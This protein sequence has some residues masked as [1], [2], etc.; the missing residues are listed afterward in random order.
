[1]ITIFKNIKETETPYHREINFILDR[2]RNGSS[3][4]RVKLIRQEKDKTLRNKIKQD[5]P[6][7][8]FSGKFNKRSDTSLLEHSGFICLDF[9]GYKTKKDLMSAK[10]SLSKNK[11]VY[12]HR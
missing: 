3:K 5:L 4:E 1:M 10:E 12:S 7:I 9:D 6:A 8:C 2:I 11:Y